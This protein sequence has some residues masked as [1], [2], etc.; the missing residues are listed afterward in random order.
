M[1]DL[2]RQKIVDSLACGECLAT[3]GA[4]R[5]GIAERLQIGQLAANPSSRR[6]FAMSTR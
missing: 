2:I 1:I 5:V 6:N 4:S 3:F